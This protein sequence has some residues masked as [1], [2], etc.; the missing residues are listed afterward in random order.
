MKKV[1]KSQEHVSSIFRVEE[2]TNQEASMKEAA[3]SLN[4]EHG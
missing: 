1:Q 2:K 3:S 4:P